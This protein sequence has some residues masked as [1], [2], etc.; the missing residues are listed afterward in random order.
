MP[1][2]SS[3]LRTPCEPLPALVVPEAEAA[4]MRAALLRNRAE[5]DLVHKQCMAKHAGVLRAVGVRP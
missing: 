1:V 4:D 2:L 3:E 5:A